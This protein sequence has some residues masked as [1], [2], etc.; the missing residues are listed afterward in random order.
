MEL[1]QELNDLEMQVEEKRDRLPVLKHER[2]DL[3]NKN[4]TMR[5]KNGLLGN[6]DLLRDF[7]LRM[8]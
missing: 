3:R 7:E 4:Q 5:D 8:V 6:Q 1:R 2:D